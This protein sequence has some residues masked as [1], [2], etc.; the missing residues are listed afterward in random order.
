MHREYR[1]LKETPTSPHF[2]VTVEVNRAQRFQKIIGFGGA[3]TDA[4]GINIA[5][6]PASLQSRIISDYYGSD[7]IEYTLGRI[8]IGEWAL[9]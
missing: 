3:F 5:K 1:F 4:T 8:V 6:L 7:G 9:G 2:N